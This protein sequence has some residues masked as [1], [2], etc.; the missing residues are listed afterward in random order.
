M[1]T[2]SLFA[3]L[4]ENGFLS[5]SDIIAGT[6]VNQQPVL[7]LVNYNGNKIKESKRAMFKTSALNDNN[8]DGNDD[9]NDDNNNHDNHNY[10]Y[11]CLYRSRHTV[12]T[13]STVSSSSK[14]PNKQ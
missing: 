11:Y 8:D 13:Y 14:T 10:C 3:R 9:E 6:F 5:L 7:L 1:L 4:V 12:I 2:Y